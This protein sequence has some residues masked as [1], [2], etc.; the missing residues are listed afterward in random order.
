MSAKPLVYIASPYT[1]GDP[2]VNTNF[3]VRT[4]DKLLDSGLVIPYSPLWSRFQHTASP[5]PYRSWIEYDNAIIPRMD[6]C[7]RLA[8][9]NERLN[10]E[11]WDSSGADNEVKLFQKLEKPVFFDLAALYKWAREYICVNSESS[12]RP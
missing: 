3:Q 4:F 9:V 10:Y 12:T 1:K 11:V 7:I 2:C 6:A 8:A 5:R